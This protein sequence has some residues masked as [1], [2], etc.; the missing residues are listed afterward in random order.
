MMT[1]AH[2]RVCVCVRVL[3]GTVEDGDT[4]VRSSSPVV[5]KRSVSEDSVVFDTPHGGAEHEADATE[6]W[7]GAY[8]VKGKKPGEVRNRS[9]QSWFYVHVNYGQMCD[10]GVVVCCACAVECDCR[11]L[12]STGRPSVLDV[13]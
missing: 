7:V 4:A 3:D 6:P 8:M 9:L 10:T 2:V 1:R 5:E 12:G 11:L 13:G